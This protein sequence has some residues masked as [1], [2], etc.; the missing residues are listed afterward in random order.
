[1]PNVPNRLYL[2]WKAWVT[3]DPLILGNFVDIDEC[4]ENNTDNCDYNAE[5][6]NTEGSH[7]CTCKPGFTDVNGNGT[8]CTGNCIVTEMR[9]ILGSA[10]IA[11][12]II[13]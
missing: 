6:L 10:K 5:C 11:D 13:K 9:V 1:M 12:N 4:L 2:A 8:R 7:L 3:T